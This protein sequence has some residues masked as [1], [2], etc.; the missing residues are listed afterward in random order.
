MRL[1]EQAEEDRYFAERDREL[2]AKLKQAQ[3]AEQ[4]KTIR[5]LAR[6]R[7]P[8]CGE[9]LSQRTV[10]GV[11]INECSTCQGIWLDKA[12]LGAASQRR[13]EGWMENFLEGMLRLVE[14][15]RE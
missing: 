4:E 13:G 14:H 6:S 7:C 15:P 1:R 2:L 5:E 10:H 11:T 8:Q 3:I 9:R 12:K